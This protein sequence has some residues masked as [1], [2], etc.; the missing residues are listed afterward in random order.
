MVCACLGQTY[1]K[2]QKCQNFMNMI[3]RRPKKYKTTVECIN[4]AV[5]ASVCLLHRQANISC[6]G[7]AFFYRLGVQSS[8]RFTSV[9]GRKKKLLINFKT[10]FSR[11]V[12][13]K[14]LL[15]KTEKVNYSLCTVNLTKNAQVA[16]T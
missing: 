3:E 6:H 9:C 10:G 14:K 1:N 7:T 15:I 12:V 16:A 13:G 2:T 8:V 5:H 4:H 11:I